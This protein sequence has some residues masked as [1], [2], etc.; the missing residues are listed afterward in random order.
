MGMPPNVEYVQKL[1]LSVPAIYFIEISRCLLSKSLSFQLNYH[2]SHSDLRRQKV[3]F[4]TLVS[5]GMCSVLKTH[6][7]HTHTTPNIYIY[8]T[9]RFSFCLLAF[10]THRMMKIMAAIIPGKQL[11]AAC[12]VFANAKYHTHS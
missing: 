4:I 6:K 8:I 3:L 10:P 11:T 12:K 7:K 2:K 5:T 9:S 1:S